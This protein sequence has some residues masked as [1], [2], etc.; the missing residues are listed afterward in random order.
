VFVLAFSSL[1]FVTP[2][3]SSSSGSAN[4]YSSSP[5]GHVATGSL[6][7]FIP[8][9]G[10]IGTYKCSSSSAC[11]MGIADYGV[12][13]NSNYSYSASAFASRVNFTSLS[14][15]RSPVG[16]LIL[17]LSHC[18]SIQQNLVDYNIFSNG[19]AGEYW[20]QDVPNIAQTGATTFD[21]NVVDNIWNF[22]SPTGTLAR[23]SMTPNLLGKCSSDRRS[24]QFY[25]CQGALTI[26]TSLPFEVLMITDTGQFAS[27]TFAGSSYV[28]FGFW[29]FHNGQL[30]NGEWYD[31][32]AFT[33]S[34]AS[35]PAY[36]VGGLNPLGLFNDAET[37]LCGP[38]GGSS[39]NINSVSANM[40]EGYIPAK[41]LATS[42][43]V[44]LSVT[45]WTL[46]PHAWSSGADTAET[47]T[48]VA[49]TSPSTGL[50]IAG[51]GTDNNNQLW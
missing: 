37:V 45:G 19:R 22:S 23:G 47:V 42:P 28:L 51:S 4:A 6:D 10:F 8:R 49:M 30:V 13:G 39:I 11:P 46:I 34:A 26:Q 20:T 29:V 27:G 48:N 5:L 15:G 14:I 12:N 41:G 36:K 35:A 33:G 44:S 7:Q 3:F 38:G 21:V 32:V 18:M 24:L 25:F 50:G 2:L 43:S 9:R 16:C 40:M 17:T 31:L 1:Q